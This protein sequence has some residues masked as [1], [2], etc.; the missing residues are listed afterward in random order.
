[1]YVLTGFRSC[2]AHQENCEGYEGQ[3]QS[4]HSGCNQRDFEF[5]HLLVGLGI[6]ETTLKAGVEYDQHAGQA[7][8]D[9]SRNQD[10]L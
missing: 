10:N 2:E 5:R 8:H 3:G 1:M 7:E 6:D 9:P 4:D